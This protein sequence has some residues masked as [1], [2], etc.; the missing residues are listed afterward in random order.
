MKRGEK[1]PSGDGRPIRTGSFYV[2]GGAL[3]LTGN[4]FRSERTGRVK[5][6]GIM[7]KTKYYIDYPKATGIRQYSIK[8]GWDFERAGR[9]PADDL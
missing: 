4:A 2:E 5:R 1:Q 8:K 9:R 6:E 7:K 3:V